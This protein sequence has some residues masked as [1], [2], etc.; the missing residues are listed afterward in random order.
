MTNGEY[1]AAR[2]LAGAVDGGSP[3]PDETGQL[4]DALRVA[5]AA[6]LGSRAVVRWPDG[7]EDTTPSRREV[8]LWRAIALLEAG[9]FNRAVGAARAL[10]AEGTTT[11][12]SEFVWRA[13][14]V[15][16]IAAGRLGAAEAPHGASQALE[17]F[18]RLQG[19]LG[20][21]AS[22]YATRHDVQ[23]MLGAV[24]LVVERGSP[25]QPG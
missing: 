4:A 2:D 24:R 18:E 17:Q 12:G 13:S 7:P 19:E 16:A 11:G 23:R 10:L 8:R 1:G 25:A 6:I 21:S 20:S 14:A 5:A 15:A 3:R 9:Q 22:T